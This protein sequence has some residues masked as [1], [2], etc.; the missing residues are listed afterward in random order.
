MAAHD[1]PT[2]PGFVP[3]SD[4]EA[5]LHLSRLLA[6]GE[7]PFYKTFWKDLKE[8]V[9]PPKLPPLE[10]TSKPVPVKDI[11]GFYGGQEKRAGLSSMLI[12]LT[13]LGLLFLIGTNKTVQKAVQ[14]QIQLIAPDLSPYKPTAKKEP[15]GGGG[16]GGDR[17]PT[18][19]SKGKLPRLSDKQFVPPMAVVH[20]PDPK[21]V[22]EP[23]LIIQPDANIPKVDMNV[24]GD[25]LAKSGIASNGTGSGGGI[26]SGPGGGVGSGRGPG[27]GPGSGGNMGG[28]VYKIG[29]GV[30]SPQI[31]F[32]VEPEY[33]EEARKAKF[34]GTVVLA[35]IVDA[36]GNPRELKVMRPLGLG[37][38]Q[39]AIEAVEKWKFRPGMKDGK[40]VAVSAIIEVNFRLL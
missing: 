20:N 8:F 14:E 12:H 26:G 40:P 36:Q 24:L 38:D 5:D 23:T 7:E 21:L 2:N 28:G 39:K 16:G 37:L 30:S 18:P 19:A 17:S 34:Q 25:P 33:S 4:P 9:N 13:V 35:V 11:W 32:K 6:A 22:M 29:G 3:P 15:M 31:I 27:F 10:V 1:Q